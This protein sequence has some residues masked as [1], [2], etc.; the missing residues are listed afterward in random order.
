MFS[1][2]LFILCGSW[3]KIECDLDGT[4]SSSFSNLHRFCLFLG[5]NNEM[6]RRFCFSFID[7]VDISFLVYIVESGRDCA[8]LF[9][10]L[11]G[12]PHLYI[13]M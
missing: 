12:F 8:I 2:R 9:R 3:F 10:D 5:L 11:F 13:E 6:C 7:V 4:S 1:K